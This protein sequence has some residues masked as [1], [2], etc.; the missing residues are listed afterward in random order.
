[1]LFDNFIGRK[2]D[3]DGGFLAG[4]RYCSDYDESCVGV[5]T[6]AEEITDGHVSKFIALEPIRV[7]GNVERRSWGS[8]LSGCVWNSSRIQIGL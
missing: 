8:G 5:M 4:R 7:F 3:V 2:R 6:A 1:M